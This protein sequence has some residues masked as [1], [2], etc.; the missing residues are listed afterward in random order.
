MSAA[1]EI[2]AAHT[3]VLV[4]GTGIAGLT[5]ALRVAEHA[6]VLV[7]TKKDRVDSNTN[8]AQGGIAA[9]LDETDSLQRHLEDTLHAGAGLCHIG[10][11]ETLVES[12][13]QAV[14]DLVDWGVRF[15]REG[16]SLALG[17]EGGHS[18]RRI[19][20]SQDRT[21]SAIEGALLSAVARHPRITLFEDHMALALGLGELAGQRRCE[22]AWVL[23]IEAN[24]LVRVRA[25]ATFLASGGS[26]AVYRHTTNPSIA[27]GDGV[28]LA[29]RAGAAVANM[30][31]VQFHPTALYPAAEHA[32]LI[33]EALRGE[34]A[35]LRDWSGHAFMSEYDRRKD[36]A[37]R[38]IVA[39]AVQSEMKASEKPHVWLD[40]TMI[41]AKRLTSRFPGILEGSRERG[42]EPSREWIPVVPAAH[43]TCGG[44]WTDGQGE[45]AI[46]G[47][48]AAGECACTGVHGAN[49]LAS[50]S[51]LE[52]VV[53]AERAAHRIVRELPFTP[54]PVSNDWDA[55][56]D[57]SGLSRESLRGEIREV[58]WEH[59]GIVRSAGEMRRGAERLEELRGEWGRTLAEDS[60]SG[61]GLRWAEAAEIQCMLDVGRLVARCALWRRESRGLHHVTDY[62]YRDN[63]TFLRDSL[64]GP[65]K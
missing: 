30:E 40:A 60:A 65:N 37:P 32:F 54:D 62:P 38:D 7:V 9:V 27:T 4:V 25:R 2:D 18:R 58:M 26:A 59:F 34:G 6:N 16:G 53:F 55:P 61:D 11:V 42:V 41:P 50:N 63:E 15:S 22:G 21:G 5:F 24:R 47:L 56:P 29:Y 12:G 49:R 46:P 19:V 43:Y 52:A 57:L 3:D 64:I 1:R 28:A 45:T 13:P 14:R 10:R 39:R 23:D 36:L 17:I 20:H 48:Y 33:S 44:I 8:Y 51:L 35:V 31:F